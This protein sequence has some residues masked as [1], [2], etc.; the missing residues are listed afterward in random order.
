[1]KGQRLKKLRKERNLKQDELA[2]I[3]GISPSAIGMYERN[4]REPDDE[5]KLKIA[6]FFDVSVAY[7]MNETD[8]KKQNDIL[9]YNKNLLPVLGTVKAGYNHLAQENIIDYIDPAMNLPDPEN[10]FG[11][12]V[13]GDSMAPLFDEGDYLIVYKTENEFENGKICIVLIDNEEA[14]IKKVVKTNTGIELHA[15]NPYYPVKRF[16]YE[17]MDKLPVKVIGIVVRQ[18]RNWK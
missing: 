7:L 11:L 13:K 16:T 14:T 2:T 6:N 1:M 4:Q 3:L 18:I 15:F 8:I 9:G 10:Y 12:L 5:M 17:E